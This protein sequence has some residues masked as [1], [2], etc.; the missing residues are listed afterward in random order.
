MSLRGRKALITGAAGGIG[1]RA[2]LAFAREGAVCAV[3]D[4]REEVAETAREVAALG[5]RAAWA[6]FDIS[7]PEQVHS[8][9]QEL[10]KE[11]GDLDILVNNAGIVDNVADVR[12]MSRQAWEKEIAVNLG[13]AFTLIQELLGP[14][15]EQ[16]WGR[17][18]N[19]SSFGGTGGLHR[20]AGYAASKAGLVGLTKTVTLEYARHGITC[21]AILPG[22]IATERAA[23]MPEIIREGAT[24]FI[25][26]RRLGRME[27]VADL[28]VF[29]ASEK[30]SY[31]NGAEI[32]VD[33]G[34]RLNTMPLGSQKEMA[35]FAAKIA[36][37]GGTRAKE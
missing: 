30:A 32:H 15:A 11:L 18:I 26:A 28:I 8:G 1:K 29:L 6:V 3:T 10:R 16:G 35:A 9:L 23:A 21:N 20:Q 12:R 4:V 34:A 7:D 25:P 24:A 19:I 14:M 22:L 13:G 31:I 2:A 27:E 33:G 36:D 17:I 5:A 37:S